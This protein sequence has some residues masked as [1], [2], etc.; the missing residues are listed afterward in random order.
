MIKLK[1]IFFYRIVRSSFA[2]QL[3]LLPFSSHC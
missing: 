3:F 1:N 2:V